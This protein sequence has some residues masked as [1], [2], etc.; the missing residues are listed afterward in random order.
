M[1]CLSGHVSDCFFLSLLFWLVFV[2]LF[3]VLLFLFLFGNVSLHVFW[4]L[5]SE[6]GVSVGLGGQKS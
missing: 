2:R 3:F 5:P 4:V 6:F 1:V